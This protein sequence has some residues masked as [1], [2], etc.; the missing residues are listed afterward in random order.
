M[1]WWEQKGDIFPSVH[2]PVI[3]GSPLSVSEGKYVVFFYQTKT[4]VRNLKKNPVLFQV[5]ESHMMCKFH[6]ILGILGKTYFQLFST[7]KIDYFK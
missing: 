1:F 5:H 7:C 2:P 6:G 3:K 4:N